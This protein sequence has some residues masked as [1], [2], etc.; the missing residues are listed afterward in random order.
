M[1]SPP[2]SDLPPFDFTSCSSVARFI[3]SR[4]NSPLVANVAVHLSALHAIERR[5]RDVDVAAL[6]QL[7]HVAEEKREQQR[8]D[9]AAVHVRVGH[10]N[11][12]VVAQLA[13]VEIVLADA[14]AK[15]RDDAANFFVAQHFVVTRFFDVQDFAL[16]RQDGLI[17]AVASAFGRAAGRFSLNDEKLAARGI[18]FLAIGKLSGQAAG[19]ERGFA[20]REFARF[21]RGFAGAR[22]VNTL[23]DNFSRDGGM[24]V[25]IFAELLV[26]EL[27]RPAP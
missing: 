1:R 21:A 8:A 9:M 26:D 18:A 3:S 4:A 20:A 15:R 5:L 24:L 10:Q 7:A 14:G 25:E 12:F 13:G 11:H 16:E 22:C 17:A 2:S 27:T 23:A 19:I 6:D